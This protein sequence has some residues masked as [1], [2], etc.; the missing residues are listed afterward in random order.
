MSG[1]GKAACQKTSMFDVAV[2]VC[3]LRTGET[4]MLNCISY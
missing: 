4:P 1:E 2:R 3:R